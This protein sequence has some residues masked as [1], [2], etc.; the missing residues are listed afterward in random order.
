MAFACRLFALAV[1]ALAGCSGCHQPAKS[2]GGAP[3]EDVTAVIRE[4]G[5]SRESIMYATVVVVFSNHAAR[6]LRVVRYEIT[7]PSGKFDGTGPEQPI[8]AGGTR[9]WT[10]RIMPDKG[11]LDSLLANPTKAQVSVLEA[12]P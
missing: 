12:R 10:V 1:G 8:D 11:D 9:T 7:W 6:P 2:S 4:A 5:P 3:A